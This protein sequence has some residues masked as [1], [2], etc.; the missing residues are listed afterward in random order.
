MVVLGRLA[1]ASESSAVKSPPYWLLPAQSSWRSSLPPL[2]TRS[3]PPCAEPRGRGEEWWTAS[4]QAFPGHGDVRTTALRWPSIC[5][6]PARPHGGSHQPAGVSSTGFPVVANTLP[7]QPGLSSWAVRL[8][9]PGLPQTPLP[10]LPSTASHFPD[11]F[12]V[13]SLAQ[14]GW[15]AHSRVL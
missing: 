12:A 8:K 5:H 3:C 1:P 15:P 6:L 4:P 7:G 2:R 11:P 13:A 14:Q 10:R 9:E